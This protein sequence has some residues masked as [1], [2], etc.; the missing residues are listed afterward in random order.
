[1]GML[2]QAKNRFEQMDA[3]NVCLLKADVVNLPLGDG[4]VD[5]VLSMNGLHAF[6][7]KQRAIAQMKRVLRKSGTLVGC[8]YVTGVT[9]RAD[10]FVKHFGVQKKYFNPPLL[11]IDAIASHLEGF[12]V[13]R[14]GNLKCLAYF[15][16]VSNPPDA[17]RS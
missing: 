13:T 17:Q 11:H 6:P 7:D 8:C 10:W 1:M 4:A 14:Q 2:R 3:N 5:I 16:A 15:E 12:T 9:R